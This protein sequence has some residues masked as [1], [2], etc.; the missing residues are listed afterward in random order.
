MAPPA[1]VCDDATL[2]RCVDSDLARRGKDPD[3]TGAAEFA[4]DRKHMPSGF[5]PQRIG[6]VKLLRE[7]GR[8]GM[9]V[10][11]LGRHEMLNREVAVKFLTHA[12][13]ATDDPDYAKLLDGARA[14]AAVRHDGLTLIHHADLCD[15]VP[16]LIREFIDGPDLGKVIDRVGR[17]EVAPVLAV[18]DAVAAAVGE[19]H[20]HEIVH[21]DIKPANVL[22]DASG[23]VCVTDFG[24]A[25]GRRYGE[26][27]P[28]GDAVGGTPPYMAPEMFE[29]AV[30]A[31][32]DVYALGITLF[33]L[34][35]GERPFLGALAQI[36]EAH[37]HTPLPLGR[38]KEFGVPGPLIDVIERATSKQAVYRY[39]TAEHFR[40]A[41]LD[42]AAE[43][44]V[45]SAD[46]RSL[47]SL[48]RRHDQGRDA[49]PSEL[50]DKTPSSSYY[51]TLAAVAKQKREGHQPLAA[52]PPSVVPGVPASVS[53]DNCG[54]TLHRLTARGESCRKCGAVLAA[55]VQMPCHVI[56]I[57]WPK[58]AEARCATLHESLTE[59]VRSRFEADWIRPSV[60]RRR[61]RQLSEQEGIGGLAIWCCFNEPPPVP[62]ALTVPFVPIELDDRQP[63]LAELC[64]DGDG[65][66][67]NRPSRWHWQRIVVIALW[68]AFAWA[69]SGMGV[70]LTMEAL[71]R[72]APSFL[73]MGV[74]AAVMLGMIAV[75][76][77]RSETWLLVPGAVAATGFNL[78]G[79]VGDFAGRAARIA[80]ERSCR[81]VWPSRSLKRLAVCTPLNTTLVVFP[82][83]SRMSRVALWT[84]SGV[85]LRKVTALELRALL[86]AWQS[87]L[88][89]PREEEL[90][91]L[92]AP[93]TQAAGPRDGKPFARC[94]QCEYSLRGLPSRHACPECGFEYDE[95]TRLW[96]WQPARRRPD[97]SWVHYILN[98]RFDGGWLIWTLAAI[99]ILYKLLSEDIRRPILGIAFG[100]A[101]CAFCGW[102]LFRVLRRKQRR[103]RACIVISPSGVLFVKPDGSE[104]VRWRNV[105]LGGKLGMTL[106]DGS[107]MLSLVSKGGV[108]Q[109][110]TEQAGFQSA[111]VAARSRYVPRSSSGSRERAPIRPALEAGGV[112]PTAVADIAE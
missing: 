63:S 92:M 27:G 86:A 20:R 58:G 30:S 16:Y 84:E 23:R 53:C 66:V 60:A 87:P 28:G 55:S 37:L 43:A 81:G 49:D 24:L 68:G 95:H 76:S 72:A 111:L 59:E 13:G 42:A 50:R 46:S 109:N 32:S 36:R 105:P 11:W 3:R 70:S 41:M 82:D 101:T 80:R 45:K 100:L 99:P 89:P 74:I 47:G 29:G 34:L 91:D 75:W 2:S 107:D 8:G 22:L 94:P 88:P 64:S 67:P 57:R 96:R 18:M 31:R 61:L 12:R 65:V 7:I 108:F 19:L 69:I 56:Q 78:A 1:R 77:W 110:S 83:H 97:E 6:P 103:S 85:K 98:R 17:L 10:V 44:G 106:D 52:Q 51:E 93:E 35:T 15:G 4:T 112:E 26:M 39:K 71:N 9:G 102:Q 14:A 5:P 79:A 25:C 73:F 40:R 90:T 48:A 38:L 54:H 21:R 104:L 33:Q 62:P